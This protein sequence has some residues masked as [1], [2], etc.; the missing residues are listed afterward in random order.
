MEE[1]LHDHLGDLVYGIFLGL[2]ADRQADSWS[3]VHSN[4]VANETN[5]HPGHPGDDPYRCAVSMMSLGEGW[6]NW[7]CTSYSHTV[8]MINY[9]N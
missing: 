3:W 7:D 4:V 5:W 8:C 2:F 9:I 6:Y 1:D